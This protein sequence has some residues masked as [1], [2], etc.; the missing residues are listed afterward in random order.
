MTVT[1]TTNTTIT[2][3][4]KEIE[5]LKDKMSDYYF[6]NNGKTDGHVMWLVGRIDGIK[7]AIWMMEYRNE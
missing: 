6:D 4:K 3:L 2:E 1:I 7:Q 5:K